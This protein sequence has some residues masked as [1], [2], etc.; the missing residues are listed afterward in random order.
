MRCLR[1]R[2]IGPATQKRIHAELPCE[3]VV[4][5][6]ASHFPFPFSPEKLV[7]HLDSVAR[8]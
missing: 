6:E 5:M 7:G 3:K 1:D 2:T 8:L 4:S